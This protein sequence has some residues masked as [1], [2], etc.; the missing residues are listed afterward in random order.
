MKISRYEFDPQAGVRLHFSDR[1]ASELVPTKNLSLWNA[2]TRQAMQALREQIAPDK[3]LEL[4]P[5]FPNTNLTPILGTS[6]DIVTKPKKSKRKKPERTDVCMMVSSRHL[7]LASPV[8]QKMLSGPWKE[9]TPDDQGYRRLEVSA[10]DET[11][12]VTVMDIVHGHNWEVPKRVDLNLLT[13][14]AVIVDLYGCHEAVEPF[15]DQWIRGNALS[16]HYGRQCI[17]WLCVSWVFQR[18]E[19]FERMAEL[20]IRH[21]ECLVDVPS[22]PVNNVLGMSRSLFRHPWLTFDY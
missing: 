6:E 7:M 2:D 11:A 3:P 9:G 17:L 5:Y 4:R 13:K 18:T 16:E 14:I 8:F 20:V 19:I 21:S 10:L 12:F 22:L 15:V 1:D